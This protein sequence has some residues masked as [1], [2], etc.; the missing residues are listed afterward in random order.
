MIADLD[1]F[2]QALVTLTNDEGFSLS[3]RSMKARLCAESAKVIGRK[4]SVCSGFF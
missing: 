1:I 2:R 4:Y 3:D